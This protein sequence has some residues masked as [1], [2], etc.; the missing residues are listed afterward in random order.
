[1]N[2]IDSTV[3]WLTWRQL[4]AGRRLWVVIMLGLAPSLI[5]IIFRTSGAEASR[6][7]E[8]L[9]T[10]YKD[11]VVGTVLPLVALAFG[12]NAFAGEVDDGTLLYLLVK[13]VARWRIVITKFAVAVAA[14]IAV[15]LPALL[16][17]RLITGGAP[18][19]PE[20]FLVSYIVAGSV[21]AMLYVAIF[22]ALG[23]A[24]RRAFM[25]GLTY[26][27]GFE[28][29]LTRTIVGFRVLSVR[30][31]AATIAE[32][33]R[34]VAAVAEAAAPAPRREFPFG[35][36]L[37]APEPVAMDTV[38][39]VGALFLVVGLGFALWKLIRYEV[40]ERL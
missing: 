35:G 4:F 19:I 37:M 40:A 33:F 16:L 6:I 38:M 13:P 29:L 39:I 11:V 9:T 32:S 14:T 5:A 36:G 26:V 31:F 2:P 24:T 30:E 17:P 22:L 3:A 34:P 23:V 7:A 12:T 1:M 8:T 15:V 28:Q 10:L 18:D 21:A 27:I 25:F 20:K